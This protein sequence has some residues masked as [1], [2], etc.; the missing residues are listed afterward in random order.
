MPKSAF[1][2]SKSEFWPIRYFAQPAVQCQWFQHI[3]TSFHCLCLISTCNRI[4]YFRSLRLNIFYIQVHNECFSISP[5]ISFPHSGHI[6]QSRV[7]GR[8]PATS[9][10]RHS[11]LTNGWMQ[12]FQPSAPT[13]TSITL[14]RLHRKQY[15]F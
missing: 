13:Q 1:K 4:Q 5:T 12:N 6:D 10:L 9:I 8:S 7:C 11:N 2:F 14:S 3:C 15:G